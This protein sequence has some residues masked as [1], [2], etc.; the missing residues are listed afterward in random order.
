KRRE[1]IVYRTNVPPESANIAFVSSNEV[2]SSSNLSITDRSTSL[3]ANRA[4]QI[5][6][7]TINDSS[8]TINTEN[9][10]L[11]DIFVEET[12]TISPIPLFYK[13]I[14]SINNLR[15]DTDTGLGLNLDTGVSI[16]SI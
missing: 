4:I 11:T 6:E 5:S 9:F 8:F 12:S 14:L 15:R 16:I 7:T 13:H 3:A 10:L 1:Q 2:S